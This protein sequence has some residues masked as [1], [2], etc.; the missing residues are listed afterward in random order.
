[1]CVQ[2]F[3]HFVSCCG[4]PRS[5]F[6]LHGFHVSHVYPRHLKRVWCVYPQ[7]EKCVS[8]ASGDTHH[9]QAWHVPPGLRVGALP[10]GQYETRSHPG[11]VQSEPTWFASV[12]AWL[13]LVVFACWVVSLNCSL[14]ALVGSPFEIPREPIW[15]PIHTSEMSIGDH[16]QVCQRGCWKVG[17]GC[18]VIKF[19]QGIGGEG[20]DPA[21]GLRVILCG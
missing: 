11:N 10:C 4:W 5:R 18:D 13:M 3:S 16:L 6:S 8:R 21:H 17:A 9:P 1:M 14:V 12:C 15:G 20:A 19:R 2:A 7:K